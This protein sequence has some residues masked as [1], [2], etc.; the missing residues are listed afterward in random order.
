M[1]KQKRST[2][3]NKC[4]KLWSEIIR[5]RDY[6]EWCGTKNVRFEAAHIISRTYSKT[7]HNLSNGLC[8]CSACHRKGH[9]F[10]T[11]FTQMVI[12]RIG[13][14]KLEELHAEAQR[15]DYKVDYASIITSLKG[16]N[17]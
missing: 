6:C 9:N 13:V 7:R 2:L 12:K 3:K 15:T 1:K 4:D 16:E 5:S 8:L 17:I 11:L 14:M 10:P